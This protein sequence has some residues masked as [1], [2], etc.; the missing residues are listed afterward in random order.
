MES[1]RPGV[2]WSPNIDEVVK[3]THLKTGASPIVLV[4]ENTHEHCWPLFNKDGVFSDADLIELPVGEETKSLAIA[5]QVWSALTNMHISR[6]SWVINLGGGVITDLGGFV[7]SA[8]KRG[9][10]FINIPTSLL[11]MVDASVGGKTGVN[12]EGFKN[13]IGFFISPDCVFLCPEFLN[14]L[15]LEHK[16]NGLSEMLKH[17]LIQSEEHWQN[18]LNIGDDL[19]AAEALICDS[20]AI[21]ADIVEQDFG[22]HGIR[23]K[24]NFG[25]T[26]G[27]AIESYSLKTDRPALHGI[28]VAAGMVLESR[29]SAHLEMLSPKTAEQIEKELMSRFDIEHLLD[30]EPQELFPYLWQDKKNRDGLNFTLLERIGSARIDCIVNPE[31]IAEIIG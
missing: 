28:A 25:H 14:T 8:Y 6:H 15:P 23:K 13:Q 29:L 21:K 19:N 12:F 5:E 24:L 30:I 26:L 20:V 3:D 2:I 18:L 17:G 9:L 11:A 22:D 4:D 7:S 10:Q 16:W 27:H 1:I 31:S